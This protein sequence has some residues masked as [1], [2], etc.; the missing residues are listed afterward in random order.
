M[1]IDLPVW[2]IR[3][4]WSGG[5]LE[6]LE[7]L[8]DVLVSDTGAEQRRS[9]RPTPRRSFEY[10]V[11]P[12]K[13]ERTRLD[14]FLHRL[15]VGEWL[16]PLWHDQ[17]ALLAPV[18]A[19][20]VS[21]PIDNTY[22]EYVD[23]GYALLYVSERRH[24]VV[25][26]TSQTA[27]ALVLAEPLAA[28]WPRG[29]KVYPLRRMFLRLDTQLA[30]LTS[31]VGASQI[32]FTVNE[33]NYFPEIMPEAPLHQ[34]API[35]VVE[36]NRIREINT[37]HTRLA[38][39]QD[40][41]TGLVERTDEGGRAFAVQSHAWQVQGRQ[42]QHAFRSML[43]WLNGRQRSVWLPTF[44]DDLMLARPAV[45]GA[46]NASI[47]EVGLAYVGA[48][49]PIPGRAQF[50]TGR[51]VVQHA[52]FLAAQ[53]A[54]E[55]R[56][57]FAAP[58]TQSYPAG[59]SWGFLEQARLNQ[60]NIEITHHTDTDGVFEVSAT[61]K[62]FAAVRDAS[63]VN[64]HP[65]PAGVASSTQCGQPSA[66]NPCTP[67]AFP[68]WYWELT[69]QISRTGATKPAAIQNPTIAADLWE[70]SV[71]DP[72]IGRWSFRNRG[73]DIPRGSRV[74]WT[75]QFDRGT[76]DGTTCYEDS[77]TE[78]GFCTARVLARHWTMAAAVPV[79]TIAHGAGYPIGL[80]FDLP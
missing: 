18:A 37:T 17:A 8:T 60:D 44:N 57:R 2:T 33:P 10:T 75:I 34:G 79:L 21:L 16:A 73:V 46:A 30:A 70:P 49:S 20:A 55:E 13:H 41:Q 50:W 39:E 52:G 3:P 74:S 25:K 12:T 6:R 62:T 77:V 64:D 56:L 43:Y 23:Q 19:K 11:N 9:V 45:A 61:W 15:G 29:T 14:L 72:S 28:A 36:P 4:N 78:P 80:E 68:G 24:A 58:L 1:D 59:A 5:V 32:L 35:M 7:W 63:G 69:Y 47:H 66:V 54:E 26:I 42:A 48:G 53:G 27:N 67:N 31:R 51:E 65:V 40:G 22:R 71:Q 76:A 38:F